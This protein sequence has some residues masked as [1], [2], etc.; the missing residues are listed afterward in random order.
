M[1]KEVIFFTLGDSN[2][3]STWSNVPYLFSK[4]LEK[5]GII[6]QRIN[7]GPN[8]TIR[9]R[10]NSIIHKIYN[11]LWP[12]N[13]YYYERSLLFYLI[14]NHKIKKAV[15]QFPNANICIFCTFSFYNNYTNIPSLLFCDW[16]FSQL[17]Q[18][19]LNREPSF[20]EKKF[21]QREKKAINH[22]EYVISLFP[23]CAKKIKED[24][25]LSNTHYLGKNVV[26]SV[27]N[28]KMNEEEILAYK[29]KR[30]TVLFI[31]NQ[32]NP[33]YLKTAQTIAKSFF[34]AKK[35]ITNLE[36]HLIG[37]ESPQLGVYD[38]SIY[39][40]GYLH[41]EDELECEI[42]YNLLLHSSLIINTTPL[43]AGYSSLIEAM[44]FYTP[45][46]VYPFKDFVKEFGENI[47]FGKYNSSN[48]VNDISIDICDILTSSHYTNMARKAHLQTKDY[49][50][51][52]YVTKIFNLI[53][54]PVSAKESE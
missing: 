40:Y 28:Q 52:N 19:R 3:I 37:I 27:Y 24:N 49:S 16:S 45:I 10:Y 21:I 38:S 18:E 5:R 34:V 51:E 31:G 44:Y 14:T 23:E 7:I 41:K 8:Q 33:T 1:I 39:C 6:V 15:R 53:D 29:N 17:I 22:A 20:I 32:N 11:Y 25:P 26:N 4:E 36:L 35:T 42:Y 12:G 47:S 50:W 46:I 54:S 13:I 48:N 2:K 43:W 30:N 9:Y